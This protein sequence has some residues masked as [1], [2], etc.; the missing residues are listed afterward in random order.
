MKLCFPCFYYRT[1]AVK[2][3]AKR[4]YKD[5][6]TEKV[7][8]MESRKAE[9]RVSIR[10]PRLVDIELSCSTTPAEEEGGEEEGRE[11]E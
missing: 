5:R 2:H 3:A 11:T 6:K 7:E 4:R 1:D 10:R 9:K 8:R